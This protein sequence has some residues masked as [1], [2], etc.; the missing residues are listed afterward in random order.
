M[1]RQLSQKNAGGQIHLSFAA[2]LCDVMKLKW[3]KK[4]LAG[5]ISQRIDP[6]PQS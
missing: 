2:V 4:M 3:H 6:Q 1:Q 5:G